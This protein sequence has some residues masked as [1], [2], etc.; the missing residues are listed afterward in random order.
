MASPGLHRELRQPLPSW[1][2]A[3][4]LR[5]RAVDALGLQ[6]TADR[7]ADEILPDLSV[8]TTRARYFAMLAWARKVCGR[9]ADEERIHA[10]EVALAVREWALHGP[11][12]R[13]DERERCRYV[14]SR[15]LAALGLTTPPDDPRVAYRVPVWRAYRASMRGL[16]LLDG[17]DALTDDGAELARHFTAACRPRDTRGLTLLPASACLSE[18]RPPEASIIER[19][20]GVRRRGKLAAGDV[21]R[22]A[23]RAALMRELDRRGLLDGGVAL[24]RVLKKYETIRARMPSRTVAALREAA[25]WERLAVGLHAIFLLWLHH[26]GR[27]GSAA[28]PIRAARRAR[29]QALP[30]CEPIEIA[31]DQVAALAVQSI[32]HALALR[33]RLPDDALHRSDPAAFALGAVVVG[34][35]PIDDVFAQLAARHAQAKGDD[36]WTRDGRQGQELARDAD[37]DKWRLPTRATLHGY[38]LGALSSLLADL[39]RAARTR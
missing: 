24:A 5:G 9:R 8:L 13:G 6:A 3:D 4:P 34:A 1:V 35:A 27:P 39:R 37:D 28:R 14:G 15:N 17:D 25:V 12:D 38:R 26:I 20:L 33:D 36:A 7:I 10:L 19:V 30:P 22:P 2:E 21:T 29:P 31:S 23:R 11:T 32:R 16:G 18:L